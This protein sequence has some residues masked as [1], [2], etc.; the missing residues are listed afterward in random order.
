MSRVYAR[1]V[2]SPWEVDEVLGTDQPTAVT[3]RD[4]ADHARY[5]VEVNGRL[6]GLADY[7]L[8]GQRQ[9]FVH[10]EIRE[11][12]EG[13]GLGS[14]LARNALADVVSKGRTIVPVC[15]FIARWI[16]RHADFNDSVDLVVLGKILAKQND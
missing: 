12:F 9:I 1:T 2:D 15:P 6:A 5:V 14:I 4:D 3:V 13:Q 7:E 10:T 8:H 11:A 16:S